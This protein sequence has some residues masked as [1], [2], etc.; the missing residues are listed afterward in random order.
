MKAFSR[1]SPLVAYPQSLSRGTSTLNGELNPA[2]I[3]EDSFHE[4]MEF[5][6]TP[7]EV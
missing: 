3:R 2:D 5:Q 1:L 6:E 4:G 7:A